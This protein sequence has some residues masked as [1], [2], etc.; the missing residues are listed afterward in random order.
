[1]IGEDATR[2]QVA[3]PDTGLRETRE[4]SSIECTIGERARS[5]FSAISV[6]VDLHTFTSTVDGHWH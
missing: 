6:S 3:P 1:V 2:E 5:G 4:S